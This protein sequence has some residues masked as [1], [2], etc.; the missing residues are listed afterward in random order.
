MLTTLLSLVHR[1]CDPDPLS[2]AEH[3]IPLEQDTP[4]YL[5]YAEYK[6]NDSDPGQLRK[7]YVTAEYRCPG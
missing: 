7:V 6:I 5:V 3:R 4:E 1:L 2:E